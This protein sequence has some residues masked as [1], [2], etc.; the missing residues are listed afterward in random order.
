MQ[1]DNQANNWR[2]HSMISTALTVWTPPRA[3]YRL[4]TSNNETTG[5]YL[6][7]PVAAWPQ[8]PTPRYPNNGNNHIRPMN[9]SY[10]THDHHHNPHTHGI[11]FNN[12]THRQ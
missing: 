5:D 9:S 11:P 3:H 8:Q 4:H 2:D 10:Y 6:P 1:R 7:P 12:P